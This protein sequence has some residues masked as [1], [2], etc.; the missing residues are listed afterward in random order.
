MPQTT[1]CRCGAAVPFGDD[2]RGFDAY[3]PSCGAAVAIPATETAGT[4]HARRRSTVFGAD[5]LVA[6]TV[7][8]V[9]CLCGAAV[10]VTPADY[11]ENVYCPRCGAE[12]AV[13]ATL[14]QS[15]A[16]P[17]ADEESAPTGETPVR[18]RVGTPLWVY[19]A[20]VGAAALVG[21]GGFVAWRQSRD[22]AVGVA[23]AAAPTTPAVPTPP[24][25]PE[26]TL[27]QVEALAK[28]TDRRA[29]LTDARTLQL[30]LDDRGVPN[31]DRRQVRLKEIVAALVD[32]L[33]PKDEGD[34]PYLKEFADQLRELRR[35]YESDDLPGGRKA[36]GRAEALLA[37]H[38]GELG[39]DVQR[40]AFWKARLGELE[41][42]LESVQKVR[43]LL[44]DARRR[45]E[46]GHVTAALECD[47]RAKFLY[48]RT[49]TLIAKA[50]QDALTRREAEGREELRFALGKRAA[51]DARRC[52]AEG[53]AKTRDALVVEAH[54]LLAGLPDARIRGL[55]ADIKQTAK[56]AVNGRPDSTIVRTLAARDLYE[57]A[58]KQFADGDVA[59]TVA[60]CAAARAH[61]AGAEWDQQLAALAHDILEPA[62]IA[63]VALPDNEPSLVETLIAARE[64]LR[65]AKPW[66]ADPRWHALDAT[67][68][69]R[70]EPI[71]RQALERAAELARQDQLTEA[72]AAARPAAAL[73]EAA[74]SGR[75][76]ELMRQWQAELD[77]RA[78][79]K[80]QDEH[81]QRV[82]QLR[83]GDH[84][85][86]AWREA[87]HFIRRFPQ[88]GRRAE[89][90][91]AAA[92]LLPRVERQ[93]DG[94]VGS[95]EQYLTAENGTAFRK[96]YEPFAEGP[97]PPKY[98][99]AVA[100]FEAFLG[101]L[102]QRAAGRYAELVMKHKRMVEYK[103]V[104]ALLKGLPQVLALNPDHADA[105]A[106]LGKARVQGRAEAD[107]LIRTVDAIR[108]D[109]RR[110]RERLALVAALDPDGPSGERARQLLE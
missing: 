17:A 53:D 52:L 37:E 82:A 94:V 72:I 69:R 21:I 78:S 81:W 87:Q 27:E 98:A 55:D 3:C 45:A 86:A 101:G 42:R 8:Q 74:S 65:L 89:A 32:R 85:L 104:V 25:P 51:E 41:L 76:T 12:V 93:L 33:T 110:Y 18:S 77:A 30:M 61:P 54:K 66:L 105:L 26:I 13:G 60:A 83:A 58:L 40:L 47:A 49:G 96:A 2:D 63:A 90:E 73:G 56:A 92:E 9:A 75:A 62:T 46:A 57:A 39:G 7:G 91:A 6:A 100:R 88:S 68:L 67:I 4:T 24:R 48:L 107:S 71:A 106:L 10:P 22:R 59:A 14:D 16:S 84:A 102:N 80:A 1:P 109:A 70:G 15:T 35:A 19:A 103:D 79:Q 28:R 36:L 43:A 20:T 31:A 23:S 11:G 108:G 50:E 29:A 5:A 44:D 38:P 34:P 97:V 64:R 99:A 95:L